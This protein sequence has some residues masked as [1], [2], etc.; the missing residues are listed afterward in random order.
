MAKQ[1][2]ARTISL[3]S[4]HLAQRLHSV[5]RP[6]LRLLDQSSDSL[7]P[8]DTML[9]VDSIYILNKHLLWNTRI[10]HTLI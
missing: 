8:A 6:V 10:P 4:L 7:E 9:V 5:P 2:V 3:L 1:V